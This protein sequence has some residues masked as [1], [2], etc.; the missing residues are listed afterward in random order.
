MKPTLISLALA[1]LVVTAL[2]GVTGCDRNDY[3]KKA[4][5]PS[6][7]AG[8]ELDD[9]TMAAN[10]RSALDADSTKYPDVK[11]SAYKGIVQLSGFA[12]TSDQKK[13]AGDVASKV[14]NVKKVENNIS[15]KP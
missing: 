14:P 9:K 1:S 7:T 5:E 13:H 12:D 2:S 3:A 4:P 6:R 11:V 15:T 10:V 8:E